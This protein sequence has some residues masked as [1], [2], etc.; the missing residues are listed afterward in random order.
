M[1][2]F[3]IQVNRKNFHDY[4]VA[5]K[6]TPTEAD[7]AAGQILV[8]IDQFAF[9][10]NN[11][12]YAAAADMVGYWKFFP[13]MGK[14]SEGNGVIPVWGFADVVESNVPGIPIGDRLFGYFPPASHFSPLIIFA[15][16]PIVIPYTTGTGCIPTK[17]L[18]S[19]SNTGPSI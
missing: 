14:D 19:A 15:Y 8:K 5:T 11:I 17:L 7:L 3:D 4:K 1:Q 12:T 13:A 16:S 10:S 6:N 18:C 9:T 2:A